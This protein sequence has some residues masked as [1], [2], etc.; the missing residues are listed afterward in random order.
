MKFYQPRLSCKNKLTLFIMTR[1]VINYFSCKNIILLALI[2]NLIPLGIFG[3]NKMIPFTDPTIQYQGRIAMRDSAACINWSESSI[4]LNFKGTEI[5][6][7]LKDADTLSYYNIV[8]DNSKIKLSTSKKGYLLV[9]GLVQNNHKIELF[10]RTEWYKGQTLFYGFETNATAT[11][12]P[13]SKSKKK[14]FENNY[15]TY[16]TITSR[17]YT[18]QFSCIANSGIGIML[19]WFPY[20]MS[21]IYDFTDS[22]DK[23]TKYN[24][25]QFMPDIVVINLFKNDLWLV[26]KPQNEQFI[27]TFGSKKPT[28]DFIVRSYTN[29]VRAIRTKYPKISITCTL[30]NMDTIKERSNWTKE[31]YTINYS[32]A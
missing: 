13:K 12:L 27:R 19:S 32:T 22:H 14:K 4:G 26:N 20:T 23:T 29:F 15:L 10:K 3:Q 18:V 24:F 8:I 6:A 31:N 17:Y 2:F 16:W 11:I 7:I 28:E 21:D 5:A 1:I 30:E 25:K 9:S